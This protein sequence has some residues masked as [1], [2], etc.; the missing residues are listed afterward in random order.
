MR[1]RLSKAHKTYLDM[2]RH[3]LTKHGGG[4]HKDRPKDISNAFLAEDIE[5]VDEAIAAAAGAVEGAPAVK[6]VFKREEK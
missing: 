3:D 5:D 2:G 4:F 1:K 6:R